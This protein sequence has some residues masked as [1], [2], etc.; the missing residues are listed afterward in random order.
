MSEEF[1]PAPTHRA[2]SI[3][4]KMVKVLKDEDVTC[5]FTRENICLLVIIMVCGH[6]GLSNIKKS[7]FDK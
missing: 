4:L 1:D 2:C 3:A 6:H 7:L 5:S